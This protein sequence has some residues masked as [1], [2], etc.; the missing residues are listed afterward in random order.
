MWPAEW[1]G[2]PSEALDNT[3]HPAVKGRLSSGCS[4]SAPCEPQLELIAL[5]CVKG[6]W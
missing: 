1:R 2:T 4:S 5:G 6:V 3:Q